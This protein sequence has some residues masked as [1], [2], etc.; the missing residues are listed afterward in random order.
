M[1]ED[2]DT[3]E[4]DDD[5]DLDS[6][7]PGEGE[8]ATPPA[9][10]EPAKPAAPAAPDQQ[11]LE[12]VAMATYAVKSAW[13]DK[14]KAAGLVAADF[15]NLGVKSLD[16]AGEA[17]FMAEAKA[18]HDAKVAE[19]AALGFVQQDASLTAME[20]AEAAAAAAWGTPSAP[21]D[22]STDE[23]AAETIATAV[24]GGD[25]Q[26]TLRAMLQTGLGDFF[27]TGRTR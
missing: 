19:L 21:V 11:A 16:P 1:S 10:A 23:K 9:A 22:T 20:Q 5:F 14:A 15:A 24:R 8:G 26:G 6:L 18:S 13:T 25:T 7:D 12:A 4:T 27:R 2:N 3:N 17:A